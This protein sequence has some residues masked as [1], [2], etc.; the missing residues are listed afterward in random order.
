MRAIDDITEELRHELVRF[1]GVLLV[2]YDYLEKYPNPR[3]NKEQLYDVWNNMHAEAIRQ[4]KQ[5]FGIGIKDAKDPLVLDHDLHFISPRSTAEERVREITAALGKKGPDISLLFGGMLS[6][7]CVYT[8]LVGM[9]KC[10][11]CSGIYPSDEEAYFDFKSRTKI[12]YGKLLPS[13]TER[14]C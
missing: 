9:C 11:D 1:D 14:L 13:L 8:H 7:D 10:C 6:Y 12:G 3:Y 5:V 2:H 4:S